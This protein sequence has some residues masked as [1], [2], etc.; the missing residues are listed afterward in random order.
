MRILHVLNDVAA[1]GSGIVNS[2][3]DLACV[4]AES[5]HTVAIASGGGGYVSLL[6]SNGVRHFTLNQRVRWGP[7]RRD[8]W[9]NTRL[10]LRALSEFRRI[11]RS[12]A[13]EIVHCHMVTGMIIARL[14]R[15]TKRYGLVSHVHNIHQRSSV[16]MR[17]AD[18]SIAVS[19]GAARQMAIWGFRQEK[20]AL[21]RH[22]T[23]GTRRLGPSYSENV[24]ELM[25]PAIVTVAGL[26]QR[27]NID[28]LM[29]AFDEVAVEF[30]TAH[31]YVIGDGKRTEYEN[32]AQQMKAG[33]RIHFEGFKEDPRP[34]MQAAHIFVLASHRE[35]FG[36]VFQEARQ[37]GAAIIGT[38]VDGI[39]EALDYGRAGLLVPPGDIHELASAMRHL[40]SDERARKKWQQAAKENLQN[41]TVQYM[42]QEVEALY[43]SL[44]P[45]QQHTI[46]A[47]RQSKRAEIDSF[48]PLT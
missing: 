42:S 45:K 28:G 47:D 3:V 19:E 43:Q 37:A 21:I 24:P 22:G 33:P 7:L 39:P 29:K 18:R 48:D 13:P 20:I 14:C 17:L 44:L 32:L 2:A 11:T 5:G 31:L 27:K 12:F 6:E 36:L 16:L 1:L 26:W 15:F 25:Q 40:L 9:V 41:K 30:K 23:L 8:L 35:S 34:Y 46:P 38:D 10:T 4:Q